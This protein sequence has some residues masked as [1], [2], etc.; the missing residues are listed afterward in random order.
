VALH[1]EASRR[2]GRLNFQGKDT[3]W[4]NVGTPIALIV[5]DLKE[6]APALWAEIGARL[7]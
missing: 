4:V 6:K 1:R 3:A 5:A 2:F 7:A